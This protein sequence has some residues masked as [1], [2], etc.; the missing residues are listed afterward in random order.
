MTISSDNI[1]EVRDSGVYA[2]GEWTL[3][4]FTNQL[5]R[6]TEVLSIEHRHAALLRLLV[7]SGNQVVTRDEIFRVVWQ[8]KVVNEESLAVAIS[9][10]RKLL[11]DDARA[12]R[13][14]KT[15]PSVGY[16]FIATVVAQ[17][18]PTQP[19][20]TTKPA[21]RRKF[22]FAAATAA[23]LI[24]TAM[25]FWIHHQHEVSANLIKQNNAQLSAAKALLLGGEPSRLHEAVAAF[26]QILAK[27]PNN[28]KAWLGLAEAKMWLLGNKQTEDANYQELSTLLQKALTIDPSLARAHLWL[29]RLL[30]W[31]DQNFKVA[32]QH[33][34]TALQL[35]SK[36]EDIQLHYA[37][38]L[39]I[40][41]RFDDAR[42]QIGN[43]RNLDPLQYSHTQ[44]VWVRMIEGNY[45][46]A[47]TELDRIAATEEEDDEF[48][49][50]ALNVY[51]H[52]GDE[53]RAFGHMQWFFHNANLSEDKI[54]TLNKQFQRSGL[55]GVYQ[56]LLD[57]KETA[58]IGQFTPPLSWARYAVAANQ[59]DTAIKFLKM[60]FDE[61]H[62]HTQCVAAD[63]MYQP[64][65]D[66][67]R[68][69]QL[70]SDRALPSSAN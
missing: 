55:K 6:D 15:I 37:H 40:Q 14:I 38:F 13:Y 50:A 53:Q 12:P 64:L 42:T 26:R 20:P 59:K 1:P 65:Y 66:D 2:F 24:L 34:E 51:F 11:N 60:S 19:E 21:S 57:S 49:R 44:M 8:R 63:P 70:I 67:R 31:H 25:F 18:L 10:L 69:R 36:D 54:D 43:V 32:Q 35:D 29:A 4:Y 9:Q 33:F 3:N 5:I 48:H 39:M 46:A 45:Q 30:V 47:A 17:P 56:S 52:L 28:A 58:D 23:G 41:K 22:Y 62:P 16:Q 27:D 7:S 68:F 61:H